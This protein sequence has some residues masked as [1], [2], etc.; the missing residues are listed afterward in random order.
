MMNNSDIDRL[1]KDIL[2]NS[3]LE[4]TDTDFNGTTMKRVLRESRR[5]RILQNFLLCFLVF[6]AVDALILLVIWFLGLNVFDVA[7][8][9]GNISQE[10]LLHIEKLKDSILQNGYIEYIFLLLV[11]IAIADWMT[12]S[13]L[14]ILRRPK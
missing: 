13:K 12:E 7:L 2:K 11:I 8:R 9:S 6:V 10:L 3:Y 1:T 4:V 5:Q 14:K